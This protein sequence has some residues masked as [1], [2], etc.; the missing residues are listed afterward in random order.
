M[1]TGGAI[2]L[3]E[4]FA[5]DPTIL[6]NGDTFFDVDIQELLDFHS[7]MNSSVSLSSLIKYKTFLNVFFPSNFFN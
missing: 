5:T 6:V 7:R 1:G 2:K 3:A 4:S